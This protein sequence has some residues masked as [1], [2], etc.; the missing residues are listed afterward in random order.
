MSQKRHIFIKQSTYTY[1][2]SKTKND[3]VKLSS[4]VEGYENISAKNQSL[5][6][7]LIPNEICYKKIKEYL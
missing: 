5:A 2:R 6:K 3:P 7:T 4:A 1:G